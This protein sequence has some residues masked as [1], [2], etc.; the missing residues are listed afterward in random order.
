VP[1]DEIEEEGKKILVEKRKKFH[2]I[3]SGIG[4]G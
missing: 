3:E 4:H 2:G 1:T